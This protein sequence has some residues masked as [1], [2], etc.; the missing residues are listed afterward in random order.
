MQT[1]QTQ[2]SLPSPSVNDIFWVDTRVETLDF[3]KVSKNYV[4]SCYSPTGPS[5]T[6][7]LSREA[8]L[9]TEQVIVDLIVKVMGVVDDA[10]TVRENMRKEVERI[11]H[12]NELKIPGL[13][14]APIARE[15]YQ[16]EG[17]DLVRVSLQI[18]CR[19]FQIKS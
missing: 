8:W 5:T 17:P 14:D 11:V 9:K 13:A 18:S 10:V 2:W 6:V 4:V 16:V 19:S 1:L 15:P 3:A 12:E 7:P